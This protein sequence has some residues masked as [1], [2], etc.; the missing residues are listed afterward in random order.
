MKNLGA[1]LV[2]G[3]SMVF[4][5]AWYGGRAGAADDPEDIDKSPEIHELPIGIDMTSVSPFG[6]TAG[7]SRDRETRRSLE[8]VVSRVEIGSVTAEDFVEYLAEYTGVN[9]R[10]NWAA[11]E[12]ADI[13]RDKEVRLFLHG[14]TIE[15]ILKSLCDVLSGNDTLVTFDIEDGIVVISTAEDLSRRNVV[16]LYDVWDLV[17][18]V[19]RSDRVSVDLVIESLCKYLGEPG[20]RQALVDG[21][22][23]H[24]V[25]I[26]D[27]NDSLDSLVEIIRQ[28]IDP[29]SWREAGGNVGAIQ[30]YRHCLV[31]SQTSIAH[32][33]ID[34]LLNALR[35]MRDL[36]GRK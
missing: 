34:Q 33:Q 20:I 15:R 16:R 28:T 7:Y 14:V 11:L 5:V 35:R 3:L 13:R 26:V 22:N 24:A 21:W 10:A 23:P 12:A 30:T 27:T 19:P 1:V 17:S 9:I 18:W 6:G 32:R 29:E 8:T 2:I 36:R 25:R 4:A 31:I